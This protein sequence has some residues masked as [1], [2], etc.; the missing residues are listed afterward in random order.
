MGTNPSRRRKTSGVSRRKGSGARAGHDSIGQLRFLS[1]N[2]A[3][4]MLYQINSGPDGLERRFTYLSPAVE[5]LHGIR[6]GDALRDPALVY[7]QVCEEDRAAVAEAEARAARTRTRFGIEVRVRLPSGEVRW[8]RFVSVPR[9]DRDGNLIW[10]GIELDIT[11]QKQA[12]IRLRDERERLAVTL[13]SIADGVIATD[14]DGRI[15]IMNRVAEELT[16]WSQAEAEGKA[17]PSVFVLVNESTGEPLRDPVRRAL[18][19]NETVEIEERALLVARD[20]ARRIIS[21]SG[22]PIVDGD[23]RVIGAVL[24]F[25]DVTEK[26]RLAEAVQ[27]TQKLESLGILAGGIA[28]DFNNLLGN[29]FS[30]V[31]LALGTSADREVAEYLRAALDTMSRARALTKQLLTFAKGGAPIRRSEPLFPF[32]EQAARFALG[33]SGTACSFEVDPGLWWCG[34]DKNQMGQVVD[35][36]VINALQA[37]PAGGHIRVRAANCVLDKNEH[38][39]LSAGRYVRLSFQDSGVGMPKAIL[40]RIFDPFFT[41]KHK[42]SG[43]GLATCHSIIERHG[44]C[45]DVESEPGKGSTFHVYLPAASKPALSS[46]GP[47][48]PGRGAGARILLMEDDA[49]IRDTLGKMLERLGYECVSTRDGE[50]AIRAYREALGASRPFR[51]VI[52]DLMIPRGMGGKDAI[53]E[54]RKMD[55]QVPA[56]VVSGYA[57]D[58][59]LASPREHGFSD[60]L[61]KPFT[62]AEFAAV[63]SRNIG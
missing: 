40:A 37:M 56:V 57:E 43:L 51:M 18:L 19:E 55:P 16:G 29:I 11:E 13:R 47:P 62:M 3:D 59:V 22:A 61:G 63:I 54:I 26:I 58:P 41:T 5:R 60:S 24:A 23:H 33:G 35:N 25:G 36:L 30:H 10:D 8:R 38:G 14:T 17:L 15:A 34:Y 50:E 27:R 2:L 44:G 53:L 52:F 21:G 39:A 49:G 32:V 28:H 1:E 20:G 48:A 45:I 6:L 7:G 12:E 42:G 46:A 4:G 9:E 31:E